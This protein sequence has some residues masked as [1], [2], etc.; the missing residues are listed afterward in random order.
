M[1]PSGKMYRDEALEA[2]GKPLAGRITLYTPPTW[3]GI[4]AL[5]S[6]TLGLLLWAMIGLSIDDQPLWRFLAAQLGARS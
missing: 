4:T 3:W 5:L 2:R 1:K 6:L